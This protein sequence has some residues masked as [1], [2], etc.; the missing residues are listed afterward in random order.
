MLKK[1]LIVAAA[2]AVLIA[3]PAAWPSADE[4]QTARGRDTFERY[5]S[6]CHSSTV[7]LEHCKNW[8]QWMDTIAKM[9][10]FRV[11]FV[12]SAIPDD[13]QALIAQFLT[14]ETGS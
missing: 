5:C 7:P 14:R 4:S 1:T 8:Q 11:R 10:R 3:V 2:I 12:G 13:S 6:T 9:S